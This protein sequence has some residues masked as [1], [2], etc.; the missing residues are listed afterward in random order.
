MLFGRP[1]SVTGFFRSNRGV[2]SDVDDTFTIILQ[3]QDAQRD[4][5]VTV[6]TAVVSHVKDQLKYYFRGT[7]GSYMKVNLPLLDPHQPF[8]FP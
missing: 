2:V 5:T 4:L 6:K 8:F 3:Y 1:T 7:D